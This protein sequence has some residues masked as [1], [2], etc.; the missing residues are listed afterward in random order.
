MV[1]ESPDDG[2]LRTSLAGALGAL[3]RY[4][5]ALEELEKAIELQPLNPEAY[6]NRA[7]IW[8]RKGEIPKAVQDYQTALRYNP[9]YQPSLAAL[10]RLGGSSRP[11][12]PKTDQ[13]QQAYRLAEEA[14]A[15]SR[16]GDYAAAM[17]RLD[18][19]QRIAPDYSLVYQYRSNVAYLMGDRQGAIEALEKGLE[20][21]PD[22]ALFRENLRRLQ[23]T[24]RTG[25][26]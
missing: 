14:A 2:F 9:R 5:E 4:D 7:V 10:H 6:H 16:R 22:N 11:S 1:D 3:G 26:K 21:E 25:G 24:G 19:A 17:A 8:E 12:A 20:L 13:E 23:E 15:L 18:Q